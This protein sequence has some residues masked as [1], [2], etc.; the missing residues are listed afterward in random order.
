MPIC[1]AA[2]KMVWLLFTE[3]DFPPIF[4]LKDFFFQNKKNK[5]RGGR[6]YESKNLFL[7]DQM[8]DKTIFV[9]SCFLE[10]KKNR[11]IIQE[12]GYCFANNIWRADKCCTDLEEVHRAATL[13]SSK[14]YFRLTGEVFGT[15]N[16]RY[17]VFDGQ[18]GS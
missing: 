14:F 5:K 16:R 2:I 7:C 18:K 6:D 11:K 3:L 13:S 17:D 12:K 4:Y 15:L 9:I 8:R 1:Q 10:W